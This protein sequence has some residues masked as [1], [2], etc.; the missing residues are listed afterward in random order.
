MLIKA[1]RGGNPSDKIRISN[2]DAEDYYNDHRNNYRVEA[3]VRVAQIV[4]SLD[5]AK[6]RVLTLLNAGEDFAAL[7]ENILHGP[8]AVTAVIWGILPEM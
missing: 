8:E 2:D 7:A 1:Y 3:L 4:V 6:S 5:T